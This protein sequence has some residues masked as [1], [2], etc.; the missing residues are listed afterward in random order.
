MDILD[1]SL[2]DFIL[3]LNLLANNTTSC[4]SQPSL[5]L[6]PDIGVSALSL[7]AP[8]QTELG[9][10]PTEHAA[11]ITYGLQ[12]SA[13]DGEI[14][15]DGIIFTVSAVNVDGDELY[16]WS[17]ILDPINNVDDQGM[18]QMTIEWSGFEVDRLVINILPGDNN[19]PAYDHSYIQDIIL[20]SK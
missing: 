18:Q 17:R 20:I 15:T 13:F 7:H 11:R 14:N 5:I 4:L 6:L 8:C 3:R 10:S 16:N 12:N 2:H 9:V 1:S 19:D